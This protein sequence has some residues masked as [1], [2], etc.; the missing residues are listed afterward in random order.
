M[1]H[2][3]NV[4][5]VGFIDS[6]IE[7]TKREYSINSSRVYVAGISN[8]AMMTYYIGSKLSHKIAAIAPVCGTIGGTPNDFQPVWLPPKP[9]DPLP[10]IIFNGLHD[11]IV[12]YEGGKADYV[13]DSVWASTKLSVNESVEFWV[14]HNNCDKA[15]IIDVSE[16]G[17]ITKRTYANGANGSEVILYT[18]EN[19]GHWWFGGPKMP[20]SPNYDPYKEISA[21]DLIWDFFEKHPKQ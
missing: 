8:G 16:S 14:E 2:W 19:G 7:K 1:S 12:K 10:I 3:L 15:P 5:D 17:N 9:T 11:N 20:D 6:L 21:T 18:V 4:D 13:Q